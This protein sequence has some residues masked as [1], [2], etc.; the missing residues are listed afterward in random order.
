MFV[1]I[2][3]KDE[4]TSLWSQVGADNIRPNYEFI[5]DVEFPLSEVGKIVE[6]S[7]INISEH[8]NS[9][10]VDK[11]CIMPDHIHMI[12]SVYR[13]GGRIISAPTIS[14]VVGQMK[15]WVSKQIGKSIWQKSFFDSIIESDAV[16]SEVWEYINN[17]PRKMH[18]GFKY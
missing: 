15:R 10:T 2:C 6:T 4:N 8:Y 5:E 16:Y 7:I 9:V 17:N 18:K 3:V 12:L 14:T 1:T 11:Y 13:D